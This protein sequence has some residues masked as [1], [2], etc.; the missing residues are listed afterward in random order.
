MLPALIAQ[1]APPPAELSAFLA[2]GFYLIGIVTAS[3]VLWRLLTGKSDRTMIGPTPLEIKASPSYA[4]IQQHAAL[5]MKTKE[6]H[7]ALEEKMDK[8]LGRERGARKQMHEEIAMLQSGVEVVKIQNTQQ[9]D[10][11]TEIKVEQQLIKREIKSDNT[12]MHTRI[13]EILTALGEIKGRLS[14]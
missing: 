14:K 7:A 3:V 1:A 2:V 11:L 5:E 4:T 10:A 13:G 9:A 6:Q 8:E 12:S